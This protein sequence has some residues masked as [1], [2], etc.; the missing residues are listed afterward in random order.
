MNFDL[1]TSIENRGTEFIGV[2]YLAEIF[3]N[4]I[5]SVTEDSDEIKD[6]DGEELHEFWVHTAEEDWLNEYILE[7][8][9]EGIKFI[10]RCKQEKPEE[11]SFN[12]AESALDS[13]S[14]IVGWLESDFSM[15]LS[16]QSNYNNLEV[17][18]M[19]LAEGL[20]IT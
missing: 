5:M 10:E 3:D 20:L 11:F 14:E 17:K 1:M 13:H 15:D 7:S 19:C 12:L 18:I 2:N 4:P 6:W 9:N 16:P 8:L